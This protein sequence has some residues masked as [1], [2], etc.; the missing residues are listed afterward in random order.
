MVI[1][2]LA[3]LMIIILVIQMICHVSLKLSPKMLFHFS[4]IWALP[5]ILYLDAFGLIKHSKNRSIWYPYEFYDFHIFSVF[6]FQGGNNDKQFKYI[7]K[8]T[9][10]RDF[11]LWASSWVLAFFFFFKLYKEFHCLFI[12]AYLENVILCF[13]NLLEK[14]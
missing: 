6:L 3:I 12:T 4:C 8:Q 10:I 7:F 14:T 2:I 1:L 9:L 5:L 13:Y 11:F